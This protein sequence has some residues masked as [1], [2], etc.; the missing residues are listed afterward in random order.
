M[1]PTPSRPDGRRARRGSA[2]VEMALL[3]PLLFLLLF[4]MIEYGV[5]FWR[6]QQIAS[7]A[8]HGA[9]VGALPD[10]T[11]AAVNAAVSEV[12]NDVGL[13]STGY[14]VLLDPDDPAT[15]LPGQA[16]TV[17]VSV[18]WAKIDLTGF[19]VP[20]PTEI[21]RSSVMAREGD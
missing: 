1:M 6:A 9:R 7:A 15:L 13:G 14:G 10:G 18:P 17:T 20:T 12:M 5:L 4:G 3:L 21:A 2:A 11:A 8:R 19:P 16:F